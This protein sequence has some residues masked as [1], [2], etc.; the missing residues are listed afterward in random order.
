MTTETLASIKL[1]WPS[2]KLFPNFK[3]ANHWRK[4]RTA[5]KSAREDGCIIGCTIPHAKRTQIVSGGQIRLR[6]TFTPPDRRKRDDDGMI[7]AFK[8]WRDGIADAFKCDDSRFRCEYHIDEPK[9]PGGVLVE[10]LG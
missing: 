3:R 1:P 9:A 8:N 4:Y 6:I 2:P 10:V 7:G 5:E